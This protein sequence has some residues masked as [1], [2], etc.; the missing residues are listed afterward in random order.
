[1]SLQNKALYAEFCCSIM[2]PRLFIKCDTVNMI[3]YI[4]VVEREYV[5]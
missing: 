5:S 3:V 2:S 1:M 4:D